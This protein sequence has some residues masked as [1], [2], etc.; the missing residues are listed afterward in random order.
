M[1]QKDPYTIF[2]TCL[3]VVAVVIA[4][5]YIIAASQF[6]Q[7]CSESGGMVVKTPG[8]DKCVE[9]NELTRKKKP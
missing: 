5:V 2:I 3:L 1:E 4:V 7:K 6:Q 9:L 8:G